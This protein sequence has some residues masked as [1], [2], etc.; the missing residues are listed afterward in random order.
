MKTRHTRFVP[1]IAFTALAVFARVSYAQNCTGLAR[2]M[3]SDMIVSQGEPGGDVT[4]FT[5]GPVLYSVWNE[6]STTH[7]GGDYV[8]TFQAG[9]LM[10]ELGHN[11]RLNHGGSLSM[12]NGVPALFVTSDNGRLYK[13]DPLT[14]TALATTD[15]RRPCCPKDKITGTPVV[16]L[17]QFS[18]PAFQ[19][20]ML[21][22]RGYPDDLVF[23]VTH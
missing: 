9:T 14:F 7:D 8:S 21:A 18:N 17:Y 2:V 23:V 13:L 20:A 10:H 6:S 11:L 15:L 12:A 4:F 5:L 16:Q 3:G 19:N 22:R 1:L